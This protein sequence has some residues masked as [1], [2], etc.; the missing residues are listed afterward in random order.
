MNTNNFQHRVGEEN[1]AKNGLKMKIVKYNSSSDIDIQFE[2]GTI[3]YGK[4]YVDFKRGKIGYPK[5]SKIGDINVAKN[6]MKMK[7]IGYRK[8]NDIDIEFEDGTIIEHARYGCFINGEI[9]YPYEKRLGET[10][11]TRTGHVIKIIKYKSAKD[12]DVQ[13]EDGTVVKNR[14]YVDFVNKKI[15][16]PTENRI[17]K[18]SIASNGQKMTIIEYRG[19]NDIDVQFEDG[20]VVEHRE[21]KAFLSGT[22]SN[23]NNG[24][25]HIGEERI[26]RNG[27]KIKIIAYR[28]SHDIDVEFEDGTIVENK[29]YY[30]F[31]IG[32]IGYPIEN[33]LGEERLANN[34]LNMKIIRYRDSSDIDIQF[35]DGTVVE[36]KAYLNFKNGAI[37]YPR[38]DH[39]GEENVATNGMKIKLI[40]YKNYNNVDV[41]FED[42]VVV[43]NRHYKNFMEGSIGY[44]VDRLLDEN[45]ANNGLKMKIIEYR[46]ATDI[47]IEFEDGI[48]VTNKGYKEF[49]R[50]Q[51]GH[52]YISVHRSL[53]ERIIC[54]FI[55]KKFDYISNYKP[56]WL[57]NNSKVEE[58][59][60][61]E[62]DIYIPEKRVAIEYDGMR[63]HQN[64]NKDNNKNRCVYKN[65]NVVEKIFR[66]R[67]NGCPE[68]E[69]YENLKC[70][71]TTPFSMYHKESIRELEIAIKEILQYIGCED[72]E[73][74]ITSEVVEYCGTDKFYQN[75]VEMMLRIES[76][77]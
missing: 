9:A 41:Q 7:V 50:G 70:I 28:N 62:L 61:S 6:G 49:K 19:C 8:Y 20:T 43:K 16:Y 51:I 47:D 38:P 67:E 17:G 64:V 60:K 27:L 12:I 31:Y 35:E 75:E 55:G 74:N 11:K 46:S 65:R 72:T 56:S 53:P 40:R 24:L 57:L 2:D 14:T 76:E 22:I 3:V 36:H 13:F 37:G 23:P 32:N 30:S 42:G 66:I 58:N 69:E 29:D 34:G 77:K 63:F 68:I 26:A 1:I 44:P 45:I 4:N 73:V 48:I 54:Y 25:R 52:P 10:S 39:V 18:I 15:G 21:Y 5:Q 33:R 59:K 71:H